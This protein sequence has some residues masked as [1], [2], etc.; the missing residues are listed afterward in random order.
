ME[1][2]AGGDVMVRMQIFI[3]AG[4]CAASSQIGMAAEPVTVHDIKCHPQIAV[5][6]Q[7]NPYWL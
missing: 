2:L 5:D 4:S 7:S 3:G 1:Y 6:F